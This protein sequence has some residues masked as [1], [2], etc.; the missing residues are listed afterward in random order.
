MSGSGSGLDP[1]F[2]RLHLANAPRVWRELA[3]R[4]EQ[5]QWSYHDFLAALV[6]GEIA[7]RQQTRV[8]RLVRRARFPYLKTVDDF[9]FSRQTA[10]RPAQLGSFL[11]PDFVSDG[12]SL[13]LR[14][15]SGRGKTHLAIAIAYKAI[16]NGFDAYFVTAAALI[17]DLSRASDERRLEAAL[18]TYT[19]PSVLVVDELGYLTYSNDAA[20]VLYHV[21]NNRYLKHRSMIF[22]TNKN[23]DAWG[24]VLHDHDLATAI[25]DRVLERGRTLVLDG[26]SHR[27]MHLGIDDPTATVASNEPAGL[28]GKHR[29]E[30]PEPTC[31]TALT[32]HASGRVL[33]FLPP[34]P[35]S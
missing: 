4:A 8:Q 20:N 18:P 23:L 6:T 9:D 34:R 25:L 2:R 15:K 32:D 35:S 11:S 21:V 17:E 3:D 16:Q 26:P 7:H 12:R 24:A 14:G 19:H 31:G 10:L 22:T 29:Q 1:L 30:F 33:S 28:T 5:E 27:T 13:I